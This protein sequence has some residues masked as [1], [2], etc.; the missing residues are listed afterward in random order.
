MK[1]TILDKNIISI[2]DKIADIKRAHMWKIAEDYNLTPLQ[3]QIL[4][5]T[6]NCL[7]VKQVS[8]ND[9][10]NEFYISKATVSVAVKALIKKGLL[11][12]NI[13][14][15]DRRRSELGV[16]KKALAIIHVLDKSKEKFEKVLF[17]INT[18]D[19]IKAYGVLVEFVKAM[20]DNG[21]VNFVAICL[22]CRHCKKI[23]ANRFTCTLTGRTFEYDGIHVGCCNFSDKRAV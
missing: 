6:Y 15:H 5:F 1:N 7:H 12:K 22:S 18:N 8:A 9:I 3:L 17:S 20:Q 21:V 14:L 4:Q 16:T 23:G 19:K 11:V 13:S 2:L 10:V